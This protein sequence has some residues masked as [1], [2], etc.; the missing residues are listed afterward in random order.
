MISVL[1][2]NH[3]LSWRRGAADPIGT[4]VLEA[5]ALADRTVA[6]RIEESGEGDQ[7]R[8]S[9]AAEIVLGQKAMA[10]LY[11]LLAGALGND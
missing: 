3:R 2:G 1:D 8:V 5:T 4:G 9:H 10:A 11:D 6:L 7:R